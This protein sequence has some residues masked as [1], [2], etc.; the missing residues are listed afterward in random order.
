MFPPPRVL[1]LTQSLL[2]DMHPLAV[3]D[4]I[5]HEVAHFIAYDTYGESQH[6]QHWQQVAKQVGARPHRGSLDEERIAYAATHRKV[7]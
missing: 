7:V 3:E 6:G 4:V 5:R 1:Y 2:G